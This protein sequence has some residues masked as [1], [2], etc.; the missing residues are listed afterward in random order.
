MKPLQLE[1]ILI[2]FSLTTLSFTYFSQ[3]SAAVTITNNGKR[4]QAK[5]TQENALYSE[6][7]SINCQQ[8][9]CSLYS[10]QKMQELDGEQVGTLSGT[11]FVKVKKQDDV[12]SIPN[13]E[14]TAIGG[15]YYSVQAQQDVE[16]LTLME[17]IKTMENVEYIELEVSM[18][19]N[20]PY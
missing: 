17:L 15:G 12:L 6:K 4:Y 16:L 8:R 11:F 5:V 14:V 1:K 19:D 9:D 2:L 20:T 10:G 7:N 18:N 13:V 3:V